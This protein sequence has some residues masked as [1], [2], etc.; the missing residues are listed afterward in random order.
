MGP[1]YLS[2]PMTG[3]PELNF[4]AFAKWAAYLREQGHSVVSPH[5]LV[6]DNTKSW[7]ECMRIDLMA[8]LKCHAIYLLPGWDK[9]R[10]ALLEHHIAHALGMRVVVLPSEG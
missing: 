2:G 1:I 5:E 7:A 6:P 4:P 3:L 9:S 10:G 8:L